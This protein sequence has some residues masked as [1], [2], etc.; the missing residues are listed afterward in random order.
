MRSTGTSGSTYEARAVTTTPSCGGSDPRGLVCCTPPGAQRQVC[1][2]PLAW[3]LEEGHLSACSGVLPGLR[4]LPVP[5]GSFVRKAWVPALPLPLSFPGPLSRG[6]RH[7]SHSL[8]AACLLC[9]T[10]V[11][12]SLRGSSRLGLQGPPPLGTELPAWGPCA[13]QMDLSVVI[14]WPMRGCELAWLTPR[15]TDSCHHG[16]KPKGPK[17]QGL[18]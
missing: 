17:W 18:M 2:K 6:C 4:A 3:N 8:I 1:A 9:G 11:V 12:V 7:G 5:T 15:I 10:G 13:F 16:R 14:L